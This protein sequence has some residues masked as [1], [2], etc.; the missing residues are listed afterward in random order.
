MQAFLRLYFCNK[1]GAIISKTKHIVAK[2]N[3]NEAK[4]SYF[5]YKTE[6]NLKKINKNSC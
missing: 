6:S 5:C 3:I 4:M 2:W 1:C